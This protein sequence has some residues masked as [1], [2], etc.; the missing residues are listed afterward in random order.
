[1]Q[2]RIEIDAP[3]GHLAMTVDGDVAEA[4]R[5]SILMTL[6][7]IAHV[8]QTA[9]IDAV[10]VDT[11]P[12][13]PTTSD[14]TGATPDED[15]RT[16]A[17]ARNNPDSDVQRRIRKFLEQAMPT[18]RDD[19]IS[20]DDLATMFN[21]AHPSYPVTVASIKVGVRHLMN[22]GRVQRARGANSLDRRRFMYWFIADAP[23]ASLASRAWSPQA[24]IV[25]GEGLLAGSLR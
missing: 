25:A 12:D 23:V 4:V 17:L 1:M 15:A 13:A 11:P 9:P 2:Y 18:T 6:L 22:E 7:E 8:D 19:A 24:S 3:S 21:E 14:A 16:F 10:H 20:E 5:T